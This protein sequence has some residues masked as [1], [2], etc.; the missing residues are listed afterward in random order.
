MKYVMNVHELEGKQ[1]VAACDYTLIGKRFEDEDI[2]LD[3][4]ESFFGREHASVDE[5]CESISNAESCVLIGDD[6]ISE[7]IRRGILHKLQARDVCGIKHVQFF[8]I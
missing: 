8:R 7:L 5:V 6:I 1:V 3:V 2:V 4:C